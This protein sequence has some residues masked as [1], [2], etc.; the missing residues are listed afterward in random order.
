V[1]EEDYKRCTSSTSSMPEAD[2]TFSF[3]QVF[4]HTNT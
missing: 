4:Q 2:L 1:T 3:P